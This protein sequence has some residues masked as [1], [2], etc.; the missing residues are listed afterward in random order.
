MENGNLLPYFTISEA[1]ALSG[2][3]ENQ[4]LRLGISGEIRLSIIEHEPTN[5][6]EVEESQNPDGTTTVVTRRNEIAFQFGEEPALQLRYI[7]P[8]DVA[9][10]VANESPNR[11][12]LIRKLYKSRELTRDKGKYLANCPLRISEK[13]ICISREEWNLFKKSNGKLAFTQNPLTN[14]EKVTLIWLSKNVPVSIWWKAGVAL[15]AAFMLGVGLS[16]TGIY[17]HIKSAVKTEVL[18][19]SLNAD[20]VTIRP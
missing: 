12:T 17:Q 4:I 5:Y 7:A 11:K 6:E 3:T 15:F 9:N 2:M 16:E 13:D 20:K 14:P 10:I 19:K 18:S 8:N 1:S